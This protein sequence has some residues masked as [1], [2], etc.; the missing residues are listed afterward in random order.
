MNGMVMITSRKTPKYHMP[1]I[2]DRRISK[3]IL[4]NIQTKKKTKHRT[5]TVKIEISMVI[6][7]MEQTMHGLIHYDDNINN[8]AYK[9]FATCFE[10]NL[11][12]QYLACILADCVYSCK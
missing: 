4:T 9:I 11:G 5:P 2:E 1:S 10:R 3:K 7:R 6:K 12:K 8:N